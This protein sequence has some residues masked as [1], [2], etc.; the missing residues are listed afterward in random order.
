MNS[1]DN[2]DKLREW[3]WCSHV[4]ITASWLENIPV[5]TCQGPTPVMVLKRGSVQ[6]FCCA[7][8][9]LDYIRR[10]QATLGETRAHH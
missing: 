3:Q 7:N 6:Y 10:I 2:G 5:L 8:C 4:A 9:F 1:V